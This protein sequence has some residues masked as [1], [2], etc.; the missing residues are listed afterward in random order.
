MDKLIFLQFFSQLIGLIG[1]NSN[2]LCPSP[3]MIG[4][5]KITQERYRA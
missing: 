2:P 5:Q 4:C 3:A 1:Q